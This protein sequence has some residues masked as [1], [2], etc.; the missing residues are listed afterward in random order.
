MENEDLMIYTLE[1]PVQRG[2]EEPITELK[3]IEPK[4]KHLRY[5]PAAPTLNDLLKLAG[6]LTGQP[7]SVFDEMGSKDVM[8]VAERV[9]ELL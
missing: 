7:D 3:F 2:N 9:G 6:K 4:G 5:L 8:K 1:K